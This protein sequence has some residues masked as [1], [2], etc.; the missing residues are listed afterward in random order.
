MAQLSIGTHSPEMDQ[1]IRKFD[2]LSKAEQKALL[3]GSQLGKELDKSGQQAGKGWRTAGDMVKGMLG[4][5]AA[6]TSASGAMAMVVAKI[7]DH[8]RE[9][10]ELQRNSNQQQQNLSGAVGALISNNPQLS[11]GE[12]G[13]MTATGQ[14]LGARLGEGG[15][16]RV[17]Q[18]L[19]ALRS[20][21]PGVNDAVQMA[22]LEQAVLAAQ[23][24]PETDLGS[25]ATA[26]VKL[27]GGREDGVTRAANIL[28]T[29][30]S[31]AGGDIATLA[32][33]IA[34]LT[35]VEGIS[36]TS[37]EDI[38]SLFGF[39]TA[40]LG[41]TTGEATATNVRNLLTRITTKDI[42]L[43]N[44][45]VKF[46]SDTGIERLLEI[47]SRIQA[48]EF[49]ESE[50]ALAQLAQQVGRGAEG[51]SALGKISDPAARARLLES[52][53]IVNA[54]GTAGG[55]IIS[56]QLATKEAVM[57][58]E[59]GI[60]SV[61]AAQGRRENALAAD[62]VGAERAR[63]RD[64]VRAFREEMGLTRVN[65]MMARPGAGLMREV[66]IRRMT[67]DEFMA[68]ERAK[69][70]AGEF[71][72]RTGIDMR[73]QVLR[74]GRRGEDVTD[75]LLRQALP[76]VSIR[77]DGLDLFEQAI[78]RAS[79]ASSDRIEQLNQQFLDGFRNEF[80]AGVAELV[81]ELAQA[82]AEGTKQGAETAQR[83]NLPID[84]L[85]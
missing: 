53:R 52:R 78:L 5:L 39:L 22:A 40:E 25:F 75:E 48:G 17:L 79:G 11:A 42:K 55:S 68:S 35:G 81:G 6:A 61:R 26:V 19:T 3:K 31:R 66:N 77:A 29:F 34:K 69:L 67:P 56:Q 36:K 85:E 54:A 33:H 8:W 84:A 30:G 15:A 28:T 46:Q 73:G 72:A 13:R 49:G 57:L 23:V 63:A 37:Q 71:E 45:R 12:I 1:L 32:E 76:A 62:D 38:I 21:T 82:V 47:T 74:R 50:R 70:I 41:D 2:D 60:Q 20:G 14:R 59:S 51:I 24:S 16:V 10:R 58:S 80:K 4:P 27:S 43:R 44:R 64:Q 7:R 18:G 9:I 83:E 65:E